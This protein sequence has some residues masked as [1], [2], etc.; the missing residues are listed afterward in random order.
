MTYIVLV[1]SPLTL[2]LQSLLTL[3]LHDRKMILFVKAEL[4]GAGKGWVKVLFILTYL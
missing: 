1:L 4:L 2:I 3:S